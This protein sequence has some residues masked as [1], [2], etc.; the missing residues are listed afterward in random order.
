MSEEN[1]KCAG[2]PCK[3]LKQ[4]AITLF[5]TASMP[6]KVVEIADK[7]SKLDGDSAEA[8]LT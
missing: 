3:R 2:P 5:A 6:S 1:D 4:A 8:G 7:P